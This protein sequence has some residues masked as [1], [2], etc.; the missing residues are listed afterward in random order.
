MLVFKHLVTFLKH[1]V[2]LFVT[3]IHSQ[4]SL[5]TV[6]AGGLLLALLMVGW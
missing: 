2:P 6:Y 3:N 1:A 5:T 4:P